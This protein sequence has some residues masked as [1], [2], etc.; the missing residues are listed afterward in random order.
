MGTWRISG[1][2]EDE[3]ADPT[4]V[5]TWRDSQ[6]LVLYRSPEYVQRQAVLASSLRPNTII[7]EWIR[8]WDAGDLPETYRCYEL[9]TTIARQLQFMGT[10]LEGAQFDR[11]ELDILR[12]HIDSLIDPQILG[13]T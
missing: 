10:R 12:N 3:G 13:G 4:I 1:L 9:L 2:S 7:R 11:S 5:K 6:R 8:S